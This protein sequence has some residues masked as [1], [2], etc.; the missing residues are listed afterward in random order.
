[1]V[2]RHGSHGRLAVP[3]ALALLVPGVREAHAQNRGTS[4]AASSV[5]L[6]QGLGG[7]L[8][9]DADSYLGAPGDHGLL[10]LAFESSRLMTDAG[11]ARLA[12]LPAGELATEPGVSVRQVRRSWSGLADFQKLNL[13]DT[14]VTDAGLARLPAWDKLEVLDLAGTKVTDAGLAR[15]LAG[16]PHLRVLILGGPRTLK[17]GRD[18]VLKTPRITDQGASALAAARELQQLELSYSGM[19]DRA[20]KSLAG[21]RS[22][23]RLGLDG[24]KVTD[25]GLAALRGME[26]LRDLSLGETRI[27]DAGLAKL[28]GHPQLFSIDLRRTGVTD[29]GLAHLADLPMMKAGERVEDRVGMRPTINLFGTKVTDAGLSKLRGQLPEA[30][31]IPDS[32][33]PVATASRTKDAPGGESARSRNPTARSGRAAPKSRRSANA[34]AQ[35]K[36]APAEEPPFP[37][38]G[39]WDVTGPKL[40][41]GFIIEFAD[42]GAVTVRHAYGTSRISPW[43]YGENSIRFGGG[44]QVN[45]VKVRGPWKATWN[46]ADEINVVDPSDQSLTLRRRDGGDPPRAEAGDNPAR[47][48]SRGAL[49]QLSPGRRAARERLRSRSQ[50]GGAPGDQVP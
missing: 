14:P 7:Q 36:A 49:D 30:T 25:A 6:V 13:A 28:A 48:P 1:V 4:A 46:G 50:S 5:A 18:S 45:E 31:V 8:T 42:T 20:L 35:A 23:R 2:I 43:S 47:S 24:T 10:T 37:L 41:R 33:K 12:G 26:S 32:M 34:K 39:A 15:L 19:G 3:I 27:T 11:M 17:D 40:R 38:R 29:A 16:T 44:I 21:L 9:L 22:L